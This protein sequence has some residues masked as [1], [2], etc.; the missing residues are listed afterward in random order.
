M[1]VSDN[2]R[3][4][5]TARRAR[6]RVSLKMQAIGFLSRRE[7]SRQELRAKLLDALRKRAR[8]DAAREAA[9]EE[10][11]RAAQAQPSN[12]IDDAF[13]PPVPSPAPRSGSASASV[14]AGAGAPA[15]GRA[16]ASGA[17]APESAGSALDGL[18]L[19]SGAPLPPALRARIAAAAGSSDD[20]MPTSGGV[21]AARRATQAAP[22]QRL[23]DAD[24]DSIPA[25]IDDVALHGPLI[26]DAGIG[27]GFGFDELELGAPP[28]ACRDPIGASR[29][30]PAEADAVVEPDADLERTDPEAA[31]DQLLDWLVANKYLSDARFV[32]SRVN[33]RSRKQ[34]ALRIRL[35]L[36]RHGLTLEPEQA[37]ALRETEF[38]R[39]RDLWQRKFGEVAADPKQRARQAR[40]LAARGFAADVVRRVVG[41]LD[42]D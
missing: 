11:Q 29:V 25:E 9:A 41:G 24:V 22:L 4:P 27:G 2:P 21:T 6:P 26:D 35:E 18:A 3:E 39:A 36:S 7:H 15:R 30:R 32:E 17:R 34:G 16:S 37:A 38:A 1:A 42:E 8:E 14:G 12:G 13:A 23:R 40:F 10:L 33:A 5:R 20:E 31:V 28:L 19:A